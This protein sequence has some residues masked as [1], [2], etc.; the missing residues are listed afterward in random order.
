MAGMSFANQCGKN[1]GRLSCLGKGTKRFGD[2][3]RADQLHNSK[4]E[5]LQNLRATRCFKICRMVEGVALGGSLR[6]R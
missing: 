3:S 4:L 2:C 6:R 1:P 5:R